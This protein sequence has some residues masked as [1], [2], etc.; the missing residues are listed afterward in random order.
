[1]VSKYTLAAQ[2]QHT[3]V[4]HCASIFLHWFCTV[5]EFVCAASL[6]K[7]DAHDAEQAIRPRQ[8]QQPSQPTLLA[9]NNVHRYRVLLTFT[10]RYS[11]SSA[12][13]P[14]VSGSVGFRSQIDVP[15]FEA[16]VLLGFFAGLALTCQLFFKKGGA[17][18]SNNAVVTSWIA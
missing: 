4:H 17:N 1:M 2:H 15:I 6:D 18:S 9:E 12:N 3:F 5:S 16:L 11:K 13:P 14:L 10:S 7:L 8:K